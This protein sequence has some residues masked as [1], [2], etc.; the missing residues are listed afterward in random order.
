MASEK[1]F[2]RAASFCAALALRVGGVTKSVANGTSGAVEWGT[3][4]SMAL[5]CSYWSCYG[6]V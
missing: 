4:G 2:G 6:D 3:G 1:Y 5:V